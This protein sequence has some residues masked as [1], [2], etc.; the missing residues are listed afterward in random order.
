MA[1]LT[2]QTIVECNE[3][4]MTS[5]QELA[6]IASGAIGDVTRLADDIEA[7]WVQPRLDHLW[8][9]NQVK[10]LDPKEIVD[11]VLLEN[12]GLP[13]SK[14]MDN[15]IELIDEPHN[16]EKDKLIQLGEYM[17]GQLARVSIEMET[18]H[19]P[20][21]QSLLNQA[22]NFIE[23]LGQ[24]HKVHEEVDQA[25]GRT[26]GDEGIKQLARISLNRSGL[27]AINQYLNASDIFHEKVK[28][29]VKELKKAKLSKFDNA[30]GVSFSKFDQEINNIENARKTVLLMRRRIDYT[31]TISEAQ[32][33]EFVEQLQEC[34]V[35]I[36]SALILIVNECSNSI[37]EVFDIVDAGLCVL[38]RVLFEIKQSSGIQGYTADDSMVNPN[39]LS[40]SRVVQ[41]PFE[42]IY[43]PKEVAQLLEHHQTNQTEPQTFKFDSNAEVSSLIDLG[44]N[45]FSTWFNYI[46]GFL[47]P[48]NNLL[49]EPDMAKP[50]PLVALGLP[51]ELINLVK[52]DESDIQAMALNAFPARTYRFRVP[53]QGTLWLAKDFMLFYAKQIGTQHFM[54]IPYTTIKSL[55]SCRNFMFQGNGIN[56]NTVFGDVTFY[57]SSNAVRE[58]V[59]NKLNMCAL[60]ENKVS[61]GPIGKNLEYRHMNFNPLN[62]LEEPDHANLLVPRRYEGVA[63]SRLTRVHRELHL[64]LY[65]FEPESSSA[66]IEATSV[67]DLVNVLFGH[68]D[69]PKG[70]LNNWRD[71]CG[72]KL[73]G[74]LPFHVIQD[75]LN[76]DPIEENEEMY[77]T[78]LTG[79]LVEQVIVN[80]C[81]GPK[82][83][84]VSEVDNIYYPQLDQVVILFTAAN[85]T[86]SCWVLYLLQ[87][88]AP[89]EVTVYRAVR[90]DLV[91]DENLFE[92]FGPSLIE[93]LKITIEANPVDPDSR[94]KPKPKDETIGFNNI[95]TSATWVGDMKIT[96]ISR[97][98]LSGPQT[99]ARSAKSPSKQAS[100]EENASPIRQLPV[101]TEKSKEVV[102]TETSSPNRSA[103]T[104]SEKS[105]DAIKNETASPRQPLQANVE[106][107]KETPVIEESVKDQQEIPKTEEKAPEVTQQ[108]ESTPETTISPPE[109]KVE[110]IPQVNKPEEGVIQEEP[111]REVPVE[112]KP[113]IVET[114]KES[115]TSKR[116]RGAE[117]KAELESKTDLLQKTQDETASTIPKDGSLVEQNP[118]DE[119]K[120]KTPETDA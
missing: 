107:I 48:Y 7:Y 96:D 98:P 14:E 65:K 84:K 114:P 97:E 90:E 2:D 69:S 108:L 47:K 94:P 78:F 76:M 67:H 58:E 12:A 99:P 72:Y 61:A 79:P 17:E 111:A 10:D 31:K 62:N 13:G 37:K 102:R 27:E 120:E 113:E 9:E 116:K 66:K 21:L 82:G 112:I 28:S 92:I 91:N 115:R 86:D 87:Q 89:N 18:Y 105:K 64:K 5:S 36:N 50:E 74:D 60:A 75:F 71:Q 56:I 30:I 63:R 22:K 80:N 106:K 33:E 4:F 39:L 101:Y 35:K 16:M 109:T 38:A 77:Y 53:T 6:G 59:F 40:A 32:I 20:A 51:L 118:V 24:Y 45:Y 46:A 23:F 52:F 43:V 34:R 81:T 100:K 93:Q 29:Q 83:E 26:S 70:V 44:N 68:Q 3:I 103:Q 54:L 15:E 110:Q 57:L 119:S 41:Q 25:L 42:Y 8:I 117:K 11:R 95:A 1:Q 85:S 104:S 55:E 19:K 49:G 73:S 88:T